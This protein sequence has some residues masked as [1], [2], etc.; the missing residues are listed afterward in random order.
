MNTRSLK[1]IRDVII[2]SGKVTSI[3]ISQDSIYVGFKDVELGNPKSNED[4]SLTVRFAED[5]FLSVFYN[6]IW[7]VDFLS[8][9]DY[10]NQLLSEEVYLDVKDVRFID[11]EYLNTFFGNYKSEKSISVVEDFIIHNIRNDFFMLIETKEIAIVV[12]GNQMDFFTPFERLDDASLRELSNEWMFYFLNYHLKRNII[13]D[14]MC[15]N[16]PLMHT[17]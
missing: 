14:P 16:H 13:K 11:F 12:G 7:D 6:N 2:N 9:Y 17:K 4:M 5:S 10:K 1:L 15:E 3:E 8:K